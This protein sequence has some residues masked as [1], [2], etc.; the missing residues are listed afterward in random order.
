MERVKTGIPGF[1]ELV[2][3]GIPSG[4]NIL[5]SGSP[6]TGKTIFGLQFLYEGALMYD[7]P[8]LYIS[9]EEPRENLIKTTER[10]DW[11]IERM[12]GRNKLIIR[13]FPDE[14]LF[15]DTFMAD[16]RKAVKDYGI[17]RI[18]IDSLTTLCFQRSIEEEH[19]DRHLS[20]EE[21]EKKFIFKL[22]SSLR[23]IKGATKLLISE[24]EGDDEGKLASEKASPFL[25]DGIIWIK[26]LTMGGTH[27]RQLIVRKMRHTRNVSAFTN[28]RI[29]SAGISVEK[30]SD[31]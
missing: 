10:F 4:S 6:A 31:I 5:L 24:V 14:T 29:S 11:D 17:K 18:V 8:G 25:C 19:G 27:S 12:A 22:V 30:M 15:F 21:R 1:D 3:G 28:L 7:E 20:E 23:D 13:S 26:F 16:I 9:Y 2:E